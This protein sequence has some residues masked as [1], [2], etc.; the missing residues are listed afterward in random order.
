MR[1]PVDASRL[2]RFLIALGRLAARPATVY[3]VGGSSAVLVGWRATTL[4]IDLYLDDDALLRAIPTL[5][6]DLA[7]N[8]ELASPLDFLPEL[9]GWRDRSPFARQEGQLTVRQFD[10]YAQALSK[11]ERGFDQDLADVD[12]MVDRGLVEPGKLSELLSA[13]EPDLYRFPAVDGASLRRAVEQ[14][15]SRPAAEVRQQRYTSLKLPISS[16]ELLRED[17]DER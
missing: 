14:L 10:F 3:L 15:A 17:R 5:K 13:I 9:P 16:T 8:V 2:E 11:L 6:E 12:A 4:D 7:T 1:K